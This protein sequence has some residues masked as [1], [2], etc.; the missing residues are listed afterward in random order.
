ML[1]YSRV[2]LD[3]LLLMAILHLGLVLVLPAMIRSPTPV[4]T[5][6]AVVYF[7]AHWFD[8]SIP[9]Y[10]KGVIYFNPLD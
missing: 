2:D 1:R 4:L 10:P 9:A 5:A 8:W 6:S 3:P 7:L